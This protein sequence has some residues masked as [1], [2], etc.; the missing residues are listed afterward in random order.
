[1]SKSFDVVVIGAGA[2]FKLYRGKDRLGETSRSIGGGTTAFSGDDIPADVRD[3]LA[4]RL[5]MNA[6]TYGT[7]VD[8]GEAIG[9]QRLLAY[10]TAKRC[11]ACQREHESE[12]GARVGRRA[13]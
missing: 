9:Y 4:A 5:R 10:P 2:A 11:I 1:M 12:L 13:R 8:C 7:C 3:I 6:G